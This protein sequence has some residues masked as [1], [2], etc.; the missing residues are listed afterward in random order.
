M[1]SVFPR[2]IVS[3]GP[4]IYREF[5]SNFSNNSLTD[6]HREWTNR[7]VETGDGSP[8]RFGSRHAAATAHFFDRVRSLQR[9]RH[10]DCSSDNRPGCGR[11]VIGLSTLMGNKPAG[12]H[13][14]RALR[15]PI[16]ALSGDTLSTPIPNILQNCLAASGAGEGLL[17][18][19]DDRLL[20]PLAAVCSRNS[21]TIGR[22]K[23]TMLLANVS[24][25]GR[26]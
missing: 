21:D 14:L 10:C 4:K 8:G 7:Q 18:G 9:R 26:R 23:L 1:W 24:F 19:Q 22:D 11:L 16:A 20:S 12:R 6:R 2:A 5:T 3:I 25:L 17:C 15:W 13:G